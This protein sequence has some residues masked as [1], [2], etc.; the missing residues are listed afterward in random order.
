MSQLSG[1]KRLW[2]AGDLAIRL[3]PGIAAGIRAF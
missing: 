2:R 3:R 1:G